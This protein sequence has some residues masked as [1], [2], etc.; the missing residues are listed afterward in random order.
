MSQMQTFLMGMMA[1]WTPSVLILAWL[2]Y[3]APPAQLADADQETE[4][5]HRAANRNEPQLGRTPSLT[6]L[7]KDDDPRHFSINHSDEEIRW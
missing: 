4:T 7:R 5:P 3:R 6:L 1:A 2:V